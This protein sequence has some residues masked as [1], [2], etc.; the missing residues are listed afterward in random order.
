[1]FNRR[2]ASKLV[3]QM[4]ESTSIRRWNERFDFL[5]ALNLSKRIKMIVSRLPFSPKINVFLFDW[6][7]DSFHWS[8]NDR[9]HD[10]EQKHFFNDKKLTV[11]SL[12]KQISYLIMQGG[13]IFLSN[14]KILFATSSTGP[15]FR[16][17][18]RFLSFRH[19]IFLHGSDI[20]LDV[21]NRSSSHRLRLWHSKSHRNE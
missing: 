21:S 5:F 14:E 11:F 12:H 10:E 18:N 8:S 4:I 20:E 15:K 3:Q 16:R 6:Q 17:T 19:L 9:R 1:M 2:A 13:S 7:D